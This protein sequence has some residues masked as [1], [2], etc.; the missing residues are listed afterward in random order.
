M[1]KTEPKV[2]VHETS[3]AHLL[4]FGRWK[5]MTVRLEAGLTIDCGQLRIAKDTAKWLD[6]FEIML[7]KVFK[8]VI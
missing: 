8:C 5:D 6:I 4:A 7:F 3:P 2:A 1:E